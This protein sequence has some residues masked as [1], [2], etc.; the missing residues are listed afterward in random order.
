MADWNLSCPDW[1]ERIS[2]GRSLIPDGLPIDREL[3]EQAVTIFKKF[4]LP[5]V[6]GTPRLADV[7][8]Q[9]I[10]DIV[11]VLFGSL[12]RTTMVRM[13]RGLFL[14]VPKK[15]A[16]TTY[17]AAIML[18]ALLLNKRPLAEF[19]LTGPSQEISD[20]SFSQAAGM[21]KLDDEGFLQKR[22]KVRDHLKEIQD[23]LTD[24][25]LKIKTFD[26]DI[27]T[28]AV[29]AGAL[30]EEIHL[31]GKRARAAS[32]IGQMRGGMVTVPEAFFGM[33]TT[34]SFEPPAGVFKSE[35]A[36]ARAIRDGRVGV[37]TLPIL[38]EFSEEQ[39]KDKT[40]WMNPANWPMVTPN[41]GRS[42][43]IPRLVKDLEE[44]TIKGDAE[45]QLWA[46]QHLNIEIGLGLHS[47][48][49]VGVDHWHPD[50]ER[51]VTF[52]E[53]LRRCEVVDVGIDGGGLDDLL[54]FAVVGRCRKTKKILAWGRAWAHT[55]VLKRRQSE[56]PLLLD[57]KKDGDLVIVDKI[58][59]AFTEVAKL[60]RRIYDAGLL[61]K[62]GLDPAGVG[63]IVSA[64]ELEGIGDEL[65]EGVPQGWRLSGAIKDTEGML[66]DGTLLPSPQPLMAW[67]VGNA[68]AEARG[69][70]TTITKQ[71]SGT[72][73]IDPLVALFVA[74]SLIRTNP[75]PRE[76]L[77]TLIAEDRAIF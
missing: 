49:W 18:T 71:V 34:Q 16:K 67:C 75:A 25:V 50:I 60:V 19:I 51:P 55:G 47:D 22:L 52:N 17:S 10:L 63:G 58:S 42:I 4:R 2:D 48:R 28:G 6:T 65:R 69:N 54:G 27:V 36:L 11:A 13:V 31:L 39:Q 26:E 7:A 24:A 46:S 73:K 20:K 66:S 8:G 38:Y 35:L 33:I 59:E 62:V 53:I 61:D 5:D 21:I 76:N 56:A 37:D 68:K 44:A 72:G 74:I 15:N 14:L 9:W 1:K 32:I 77:E 64:L 12:D 23:L 57:F 3:A 45:V 70:A 41:V 43:R 40:F 30:I 29:L